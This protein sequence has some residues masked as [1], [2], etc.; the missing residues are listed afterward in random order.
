[1]ILDVEAPYLGRPT[2]FHDQAGKDVDQGRLAGTIRSQQ[3][4][5]LAARDIEA[6]SIKRSLRLAPFGPIGFAQFPDADCG[7]DHGDSH[8]GAPDIAKVA[9]VNDQFTLII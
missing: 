3:A 9:M 5:D 2:A 8:S 4:K 7:L 6:H 1:M